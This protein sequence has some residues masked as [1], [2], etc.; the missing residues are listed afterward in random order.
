MLTE[1]QRTKRNI[2][3][4]KDAIAAMRMWPA[5]YAAS[6]GGCMDFWDDLTDRR[7][8]YVRDMLD[9]LDECPRRATEEGD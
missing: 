5:E 2:N 3:P 6:G 9:R 4:H 7:K 8:R 1:T